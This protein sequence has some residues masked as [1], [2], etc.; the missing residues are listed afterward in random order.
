MEFFENV[1]FEL[2]QLGSVPV[3]RSG[4]RGGVGSPAFHTT[5]PF[6]A[7]SLWVGSSMCNMSPT[8]QHFVGSHVEQFTSIHL[9]VAL[10]LLNRSSVWYGPESWDPAHIDPVGSMERC[11][12]LQLPDK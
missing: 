3:E 7:G 10:D 1:I 8:L 5:F 12:G 4:Q 6:T 9:S 2:K 11:E